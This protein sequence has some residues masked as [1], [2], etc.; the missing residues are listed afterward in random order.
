[1]KE[2]KVIEV[3]VQLADQLAVNGKIGELHNLTEG[4]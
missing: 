3:M 2:T 4:F 1:M